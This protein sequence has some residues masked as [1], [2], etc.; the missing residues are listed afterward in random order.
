MWSAFVLSE[1]KLLKAFFNDLS[2]G[3]AMGVGAY[4]AAAFVVVGVAGVFDKALPIF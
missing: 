3:T 2:E 4:A 1:F